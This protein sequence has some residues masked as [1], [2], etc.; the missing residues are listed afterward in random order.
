M[1]KSPAPKE[2]GS[3]KLSELHKSVSTKLAAFISNFRAV[4][5]QVLVSRTEVSNEVFFHSDFQCFISKGK[6]RFVSSDYV[7]TVGVVTSK[8]VERM[9]LKPSNSPM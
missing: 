8:P 9:T 4:N 7:E 3:V 1:G 5:K 6:E 2:P